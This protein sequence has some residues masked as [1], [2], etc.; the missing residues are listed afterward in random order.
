MSQDIGDTSGCLGR[1]AAGSAVADVGDAGCGA[2]VLDED[3]ASRSV[4]VILSPSAVGDD[5]DL[6]EAVRPSTL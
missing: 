3:L 4:T 1:G 2:G 6:F 5:Q